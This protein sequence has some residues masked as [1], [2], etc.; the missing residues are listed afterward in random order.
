MRAIL[1]LAVLL[2]AET[3]TFP[4][5]SGASATT[6]PAIKSPGAPAT[7]Q[8]VKTQKQRELAHVKRIYV[9][10]FG[11]DA[12]SQQMQAMIVS[13]L[14]DSNRFVVTEER[15]RADAVLRGTATEKTTS[16]LH[17][18]GSG[19]SVATAHGGYSGSGSGND[20]GFSSHI[21]GGMAAAQGAISDSS[22]NTETIEYARASVRL[23]N[24]EGDVIWTS[25]QESKGAKFKGASADVADKIVKQLLRD[26]EKSNKPPAT[27][28]PT[29][30]K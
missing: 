29:S 27:E 16:E 20:S 9:E 1:A 17:A 2:L 7:T 3:A 30:T 26:V 23:V 19:T 4:Q 13:S 11:N 18:Y 12:I 24:T 25:T 15:S 21:S 6:E 8:D 28:S 5:T 22:V 14:T 10:A